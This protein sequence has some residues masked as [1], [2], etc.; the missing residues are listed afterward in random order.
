MNYIFTDAMAT[1]QIVLQAI[2]LGACIA[3]AI[4]A[5]IKTIKDFFK[6]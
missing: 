4:Y 5:I 1:W 3:I 2:V 6:F